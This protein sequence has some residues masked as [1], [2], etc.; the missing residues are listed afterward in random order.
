MRYTLIIYI[1][2]FSCSNCSIVAN[3][4]KSLILQGFQL[5]TKFHTVCSKRSKPVA[6]L[7]ETSWN[8]I[9]NP[10][11]VSKFLVSYH[12]DS[13]NRRKRRTGAQK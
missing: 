8:I 13:R 5:A 10:F 1:Y 4:E 12:H 11:D 6:D 7:L 3:K 9:K 2:I